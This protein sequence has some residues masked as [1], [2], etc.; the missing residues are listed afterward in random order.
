MITEMRNSLEGFS[1][2]FEQAEERIGKL[3][4][5]NIEIIQTE[6]QKEKR[7]KKNDESPRNQW[8]NH[9]GYQHMTHRR[10]SRRKKRER[11]RKNDLNGGKLPK[12]DEDM[13]IHIQEAQ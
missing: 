5:K 3:E 12:S 4:D 1:S 8:G 11:G 6:K 7:M 2:R 10:P 13:D 9:H